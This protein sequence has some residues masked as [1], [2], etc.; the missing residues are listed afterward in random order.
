MVSLKTTAWV[1][2]ISHPIAARK[3][4][5]PPKRP[6]LGF[7]SYFFVLVFLWFPFR[8]LVSP[9]RT[10]PRPPAAAR[11]SRPRTPAGAGLR[12]HPVLGRGALERGMGSGD[13]GSSSSWLLRLVPPGMGRSLKKGAKRTPRGLVYFFGGEVSE[14]RQSQ[15][16]NRLLDECIPVRLQVSTV[17]PQ[18]LQQLGVPLW[19]KYCKGQTRKLDWCCGVLQSPAQRAPRLERTS[20][21]LSLYP[22][23]SRSKVRISNPSLHLKPPNVLPSLL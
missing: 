7:T 20:L 5:Q 3:G 14:K 10:A 13:C 22:A 21:N 4:R 19:E 23:H 6:P 11:P 18:K 12:A 2:S 1:H 17:G 9:G 8:P 16:C 15:I